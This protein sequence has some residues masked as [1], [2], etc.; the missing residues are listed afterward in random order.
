MRFSALVALAAVISSFAVTARADVWE[1]KAPWDDTAELAFSTWIRTLPMDIFTKDSSP[2]KGIPTDCADAVYSLRTIFASEHGLAVKFTGSGGQDL[3][4][5]NKTFDTI[6]DPALR[7]RKFINFVRNNT[8]TQ[9]LV[10]D[11]YP[12]AIT[13]KTVRGGTLFVHPESGPNSGVPITY[14]AGHVYY[15]QDVYQNGMVRFFSSTVPVAV[16]DLQPRIDI[17]F[18]P[19]DVTGGFRDWKRPDSTV[20]P[21]F[22]DRDQFKM[23]GWYKNGYRDGNLWSNWSKAV[24]ARLQLRDATPKEELSAKVENV[25][26]YIKERTRLV[27]ESWKLYQTKYHGQS[28]M[29]AGDYDSYSTP[30][31]DVKIQNEL[32]YLHDA[33]ATYLIS[34]G[35]DGTDYSIQ[36]LLSQY[37][38]QIMPGVTVDLNQMWTTFETETVLSISEPEHSPSVRWGLESIKH[39]PCPQRAKQYVGGEH[40]QD[41]EQ[42]DH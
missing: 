9:T 10:A 8:N 37:T 40:L 25:A 21:G 42:G 14:R 16:R 3:S 18:A 36:E 5:T 41:G 6:A 31:R 28:C 26:G 38:Y 13:R 39:W 34:T 27:N 22:N 4:N 7:I 23:A 17:V 19:F 29:N 2:Y 24:R 15:I 32:Q 1:T 33:A 35:S 20:M 11:T 30:T 12:V